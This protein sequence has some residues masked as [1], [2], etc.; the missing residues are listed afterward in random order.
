MASSW[1]PKSRQTHSSPR[2]AEMPVLLRIFCGCY[3]QRVPVQSNSNE[4]SSLTQGC[5][6]EADSSLQWPELHFGSSP[7][8][9]REAQLES[10]TEPLPGDLLHPPILLTF[11]Q[12]FFQQMHFTKNSKIKKSLDIQI[13]WNRPQLN[14]NQVNIDH[15]YYL[16]PFCLNVVISS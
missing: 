9:I 1:L 5:N 15:T 7:G 10:P 6:S 16:S 12:S 2:T 4:A 3:F 11:L 8:V 13:W 14:A